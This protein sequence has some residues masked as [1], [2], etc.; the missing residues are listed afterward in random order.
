MLDFV[1]INEEIGTPAWER[2]NQLNKLNISKSLGLDKHHP[3]VL[4]E[5]VKEIWDLSLEM[6]EKWESFVEYE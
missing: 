5:L 3:K 6:Q 1:I 2:N 4:T